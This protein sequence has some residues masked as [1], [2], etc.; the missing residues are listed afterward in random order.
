MTATKK[1]YPHSE[2]LVETEWLEQHLDKPNLRVFDCT[3]NVKPNPDS[4]KR[5]Q[6]P[7][8][9]QGG[10][11]HYEHAHIPGA[12]FIDIPGKLSAPSKQYP[13]ILPDENQF[14]EVM[15]HCGISNNDQVILYSSSEPIW[16]ARVWWMLRA[17]GFDNA[18]ILNGGWTKWILEKHLVSNKPCNYEKSQFTARKRSG[19]FVDKDDVLAAIN[20]EDVRIINALPSSIFSGSS[21]VVFGRKGRISSSVNV[22]FSS[23]HNAL[24]G[25]YLSNDQLRKLFNDVNVNEAK[26]IITY[27]GGGIAASNTAFTLAMLG[28][29]NVAVYDGSMLEWGN[30]ASMPMEMN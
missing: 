6:V 21:D 13:L 14:V 3:V 17:F 8:V 28:H 15:S 2:Y 18:A 16:A 26:Q 22:P 11:E 10:L 20:D 25:D 19:A 7:F 9:Y 30:D 5:E 4:V 27:C 1:N 23:L 24:N 12:G 29:D